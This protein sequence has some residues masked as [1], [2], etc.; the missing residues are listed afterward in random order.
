MIAVPFRSCV[1]SAKASS[2]Q[3]PQVLTSAAV[4]SC[5]AR[6]SSRRT[7]HTACTAGKVLHASLSGSRMAWYSSTAA[8]PSLASHG[9]AMSTSCTLDAAGVLSES[10]LR[11]IATANFSGDRLARLLRSSAKKSASC[12]AGDSPSLSSAARPFALLMALMASMRML[13]AAARSH[14]RLAKS[15]RA[16]SKIFLQLGFSCA[17][18]ARNRAPMPMRR[19]SSASRCSWRFI[20][21]VVAVELRMVS[22]TSSV[23][24]SCA[25]SSSSK[26]R[27][28]EKP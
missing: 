13:V 1:E 12:S 26:V 23:L 21:F 4:G 3:R 28:T 19:P 18:P 2:T 17:R 27:A 24:S 9:N 16:A 5:A 6:I 20:L 14:F 22:S 8:A 11:E 15:C 10:R 7:S 25:G